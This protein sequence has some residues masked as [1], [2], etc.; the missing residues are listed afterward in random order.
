[1]SLFTCLVQKGA[2]HGAGIQTPFTDHVIQYFPMDASEIIGVVFAT[3]IM[4]F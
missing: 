4:A 3:T 1:M 2:I